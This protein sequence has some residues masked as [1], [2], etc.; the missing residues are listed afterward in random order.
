V[1]VAERDKPGGVCVNW[2]C[3]PSKA[4]LTS[5][6]LYEEM[7]NAEAHGIRCQGLSA[8]YGAVIRRSRKVADRMSRGI[9]YL[10][11]KNRIELFPASATVLSPT[12]VRW[13]RRSSRRRTSSWP[14]ERRCGGCR[15]SSPTAG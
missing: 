14:P 15:G 6:G 9:T 2:G 10:F 13:G 12:T 8:D 11:K 3:I 4:I 7:R 1:A 5:A